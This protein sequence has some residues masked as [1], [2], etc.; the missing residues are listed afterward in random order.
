MAWTEWR[1]LNAG[2]MRWH[3][4]FARKTLETSDPQPALLADFPLEELRTLR[5]PVVHWTPSM[6]TALLWSE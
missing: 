2:P 3:R 1:G 4:D 6:S 5:Q